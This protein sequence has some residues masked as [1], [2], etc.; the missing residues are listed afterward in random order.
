[1][2]NSKNIYKCNCK[3][4]FQ[5]DRYGK[6]M[7]VHTYGEKKYAAN[8]GIQCTVCGTIKPASLRK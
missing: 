1:M 6:N 5:D 8:P 4:K 3:S 7:R 2:N